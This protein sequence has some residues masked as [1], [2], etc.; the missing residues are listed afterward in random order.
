MI[1]QAHFSG[2][3]KTESYRLIRLIAKFYYRQIVPVLSLNSAVETKFSSKYIESI[4][5]IKI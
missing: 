3:L 1:I 4:D 5:L 2:A